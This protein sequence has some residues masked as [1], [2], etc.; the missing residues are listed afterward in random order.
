[1]SS[2]V[3]LSPANVVYD[4]ALEA[5][6]TAITVAA[7]D[8]LPA[9]A[10]ELARLDRLVTLRIVGAG[11]PPDPPDSWLETAEAA[12]RMGFSSSWLY[13]HKGEFAFCR[14]V[15]GRYRFSEKGLEQWKRR[16]K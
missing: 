11:Q 2:P 6:E 1:M 5:L 8:A 14:K 4:H 12:K 3:R 15:G 13:E 7:P 10:G 16:G 9:I